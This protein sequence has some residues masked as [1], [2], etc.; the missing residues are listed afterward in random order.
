MSGA[1]WKNKDAERCPE[2]NWTLTE[3]GKVDKKAKSK[4]KWK[5]EQA[6]R[7]V[8]RS[9]WQPVAEEEPVGHLG[10][11]R[12]EEGPSKGLQ[13]CDTGLLVAREHVN[14]EGQ[15]RV[16]KKKPGGD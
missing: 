1:G 13:T 16:G 2:E 3:P 14:P 15:S 5:E 4:G 11:S 7:A 6:R 12:E 8:P 9:T 10:Q